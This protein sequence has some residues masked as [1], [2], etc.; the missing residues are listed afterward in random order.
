M[1]SFRTWAVD[2]KISALELMEQYVQKNATG[3]G[4]MHWHQHGC[5]LGSTA[6][7][8]HEIRQKIAQDDEKFINALWAFYVA[9]TTDTSWFKM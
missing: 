7:E 6:E 9:L 8:T 3:T 1:N 5:G 2:R 4:E